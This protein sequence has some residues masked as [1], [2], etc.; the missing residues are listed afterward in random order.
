VNMEGKSEVDT[1][2]EVSE[3]IKTRPRPINADQQNVKAVMEVVETRMTMAEDVSKVAM[4]ENNWMNMVE[5][6]GMAMVKVVSMKVVIM[7]DVSTKVVSMKAVSMKVVSMMD[8]REAVTVENNRM[9]MVDDVS[10]AATVENNRMAMVN[11]GMS[12]VKAV[13][14][15]VITMKD[16]STKVVSMKAARMKVVSMKVV[17]R[18]VMEAEEI[19]LRAESLFTLNPTLFL[20][21]QVKF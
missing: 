9:T 20:S 15:K 17:R 3:Y 7:K 21:M 1:A 4:V 14:T 10:K 2:V 16:V 6:S 11:S 8:E 12:M 13:S 19:C 18:E 5:D